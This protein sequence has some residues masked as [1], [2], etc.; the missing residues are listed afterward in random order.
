MISLTNYLIAANVLM[1]LGYTTYFGLYRKDEH[2]KFN[3]LFLFCTA[4]LAWLI[5][6]FPW[7][8]FWATPLEVI[9][10]EAPQLLETFTLP[11]EVASA[12]ETTTITTGNIPERSNWMSSILALASIIYLAI[13]TTLFIRF[14]VSL[15]SLFRLV[16]RF[17]RERRG[18]HVLLHA[19][20]EISPFSFF[21]M[22]ILN[23][24]LYQQEQYELIYQHELVH[25]RQWHN[26]DILI[27][28]IWCIV[29]W[30]NP[31]AWKMKKQI[32][33]NLEFIADA[34]V[35]K[36]GVNRK[37]YHYCLLRLNVTNN[38]HV[39]IANHFNQSLLKKRIIMMN[40]KKSPDT[41]SL[42]HLL[43]LPLLA[44]MILASQPLQSQSQKKA[45]T[46]YDASS[47]TT[48]SAS[49]PTDYSATSITDHL[50]DTDS[51]PFADAPVMQGE[52][53]YGIVNANL[54][55][56]DLEIMKGEFSKRGIKIQ[57]SDIN[58][59]SEGKFASIKLEITQ[60]N[61]HKSS[62]KLENG[63]APIDGFICVFMK[64]D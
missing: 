46:K 7:S 17:P 31:L 16:R 33:Q 26:L 13:T 24:R 14:L 18:D 8:M 44:A 15:G 51:D 49:S 61:Q 3:R 47:I 43:L 2:F 34:E 32:R 62:I 45:G 6:L 30:F 54:T 1:A 11:G 42:K 37:V 25:A 35:L 28:E 12:K 39:Q 56:E 27:A 29:S 9:A 40:R 5:P 58:F 22:I 4:V 20:Q 60:W 53:L 52:T 48:H 10:F 59:T 64:H 41:L 63:D 21:K 38:Q 50:G 19:D 36:I 23:P 55:M 57:A